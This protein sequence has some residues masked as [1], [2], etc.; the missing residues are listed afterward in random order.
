M[1]YICFSISGII[2]FRVAGGHAPTIGE[3]VLYSGT[4]YQILSRV[5]NETDT[6]IVSE[7]AFQATAV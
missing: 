6:Y 1:N 7:W 2:A 4:Y 3:T 5:I